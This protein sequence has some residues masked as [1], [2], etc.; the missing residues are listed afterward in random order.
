MSDIFRLTNQIK[1]Y[2]WGSPD[3]IPR[4]LGVDGGG[5]PWAE[6][7]MGVHNAG[8]SETEFRGK[9]IPLINLI[10]D[11]PPRALGKEAA[12]KF[13][14]LPFL[15]KLLAAAKPLSIQ[16]HP[17]S[18]QA[19][20]GWERENRAGIPIDS[21]G[22]NYK[23]SNHKPEIICALSPFTAM[24]G[25]QTPQEILHGLGLLSAGAPSSLRE[26]LMPLMTALKNKSETTALRGFLAALFAMPQNISGELSA[27]IITAAGDRA[28]GQG[29]AGEGD[30]LKHAARFAE[31]YPGDPS[32]I[33]PFY[34]NLIELKAGEAIGLPAGV[35]HAYIQ[36][37]GAELMANSDN[38]LRGGLT[39]KHVDVPELLRILDF[40]PHRPKIISPMPDGGLPPAFFTYPGSFDEF[41]L[42]VL[43]NPGGEAAFPVPGP[44][45]VIVT[46]G[47]MR[48][49]SKQDL[50]L[51]QG[52]SAFITACSAPIQCSGTFTAHIASLPLVNSLPEA[53]S[54]PVWKI[55]Q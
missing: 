40:S 43:R 33:S 31:L 52:E 4:L 20:E 9:K 15:F 35:L 29:G 28:K 51:K 38:V 47:D 8:P 6:L 12:K 55:R 32:V 44:A 37:F 34:L 3:F 19:K 22:R 42:S 7:W 39:P 25:F 54:A 13:G 21:P 14:G 17:N 46:A 11:N 45:I 50:L 49:G 36:G 27:Y 10:A 30:R 23:D 53:G 24:C 16:A 2:D 5:T 48:L 41:S 26:G 18:V 1:H